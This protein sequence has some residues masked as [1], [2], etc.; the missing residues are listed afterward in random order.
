MVDVP[1]SRTAKEQQCDQRADL[2]LLVV[3]LFLFWQAEKHWEKITIYAWEIY[4]LTDTPGD[5]LKQGGGPAVIGLKYLE[6]LK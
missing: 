4:S 2:N 1:P 5:R 6:K 3:V